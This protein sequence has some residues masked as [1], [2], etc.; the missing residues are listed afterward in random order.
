MPT[1]KITNIFFAEGTRLETPFWGKVQNW[2]H[3]FCP[4]YKIRN[5]FNAK[6]TRLETAFS[7]QNPCFGG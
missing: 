1:Y 5:S 2:K 6:D 3:L 7:L 4:K